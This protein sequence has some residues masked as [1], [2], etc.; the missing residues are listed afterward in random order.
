MVHAESVISS[1]PEAGRQ[2][3]FSSSSAMRAGRRLRTQQARASAAASARPA[4]S[5]PRSCPMLEKRWSVTT[6]ADSR[7]RTRPLADKWLAFIT[8]ADSHRRTRCLADKPLSFTAPGDGRRR[9]SPRSANKSA[10]RSS[11]VELHNQCAFSPTP[12]T[13]RTTAMCR[14]LNLEVDP[15]PRLTVAASE[16]QAKAMLEAFVSIGV[17]RFD[18]VVGES[19]RK[20]RSGFRDC[21]GAIL[22]KQLRSSL[23]YAEWKDESLFLRPLSP[24]SAHP[25]VRPGRGRVGE[26][27]RNRLPCSL[28]LTRIVGSQDRC[29]QFGLRS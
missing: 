9:S 27:D 12:G 14:Q 4:D 17:P 20:S 22:A 1:T 15:K 29:P 5:H 16:C 23:H 28:S 26:A 7:L 24:V 8:S 13:E 21:P 6:P 25:T 11:G 3:P 10:F 19:L 18:L 2:P